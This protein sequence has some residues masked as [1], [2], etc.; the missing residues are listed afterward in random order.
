[1]VGKAR[2]T[3]AAETI[4]NRL[5][6]EESVT[7]DWAG[8]GQA[9]SERIDLAGHDA[10]KRRKKARRSELK[11]IV[12]ASGLEVD[13]AASEPPKFRRVRILGDLNAGRRFHRNVKARLPVLGSVT[14]T[15]LTV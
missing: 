6:E 12:A 15:P 5:E 13:R 1:M 8:E 9:R 4:F 10:A 3:R 11:L 7:D 2:H 14:S